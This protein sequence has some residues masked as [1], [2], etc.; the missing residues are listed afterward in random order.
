MPRNMRL[1]LAALVKSL[2]T[3][4]TVPASHINCFAALPRT[5]PRRMAK[6]LMWEAGSVPIVSTKR[7][8]AHSTLIALVKFDVLAVQNEAESRYQAW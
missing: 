4:G 6:R 7:Q 5:T 2:Q 1:L 8:G 3:I